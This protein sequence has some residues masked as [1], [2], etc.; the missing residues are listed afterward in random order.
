MPRLRLVPPG[1]HPEGGGGSRCLSVRFKWL[2]AGAKKMEFLETARGKPWLPVRPDGYSTHL[3]TP[4]LL[5]TLY[6]VTP[7]YSE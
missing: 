7:Y 4:F 5:F 6:T 1:V 2:H 3:P